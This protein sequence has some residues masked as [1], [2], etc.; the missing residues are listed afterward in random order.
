[1]HAGVRLDRFLASSDHL[2]SRSRARAA[3]ERGQVFLNGV[4][5]AASD[6]GTMLSVG[7]RVQCWSDRPGSAKRRDR[8][9]A[10][11]ELTILYEDEAVI[12]V[13]KPAGLLTVPL[14]RRADSPSVATVLERHLRSSRTHKPF[15]VHRL[16]RDTSGIVVF[17]RTARAQHALRD[18]FERQEPERVYWALV[19]GRPKPPSGQWR[20]RLVWDQHALK[21]TVAGERDPRAAEAVSEYRV[22]ESFATTSLVEVRLRTGK[23]NQI[24][25]QAAQHGHPLVGERQY[26]SEEPVNA[27]VFPRQALH[28]HRLAF[29]HPVD[30][31]SLRFESPLPQDLTRLLAN[32]RLSS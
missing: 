3:L 17:A 24:R 15:V 2:A 28:A 23:R 26:V 5:V 21:Q 20:D 31:R 19:Y 22:V 10:V 13:D 18:Q 9:V 8:A 29:H 32:V 14:S 27:I 30:G 11:G 16:D 7:D 25:I 12:V 6:A 1:M 4:E